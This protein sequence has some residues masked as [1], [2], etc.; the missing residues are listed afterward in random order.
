M[1]IDNGAHKLPI[2]GVA[3]K[4][5]T[6]SVMDLCE[7]KK[8]KSLITNKENRKSADASANRYVAKNL[9]HMLKFVREL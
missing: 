4:D 1:I 5:N 3:R 2:T 7:S 9:E 6:A 8:V